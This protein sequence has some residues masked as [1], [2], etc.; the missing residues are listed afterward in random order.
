[1]KKNSQTTA[2]TYHS[3]VLDEFLSL[4]TPQEL[5]RTEKRM[6]MASKIADAM[7]QK[8]IANKQLAEKTGQ[9][10]SVITKWLSGGHNFTLDTL[11]DI[12]RALGVRLLNLEEKQAQQVEMKPIHLSREV[13]SDTPIGMPSGRS[14]SMSVSREGNT[15]TP[16][17]DFKRHLRVA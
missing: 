15:K 1:M 11:T 17:E 3:D 12:Q 14:F 16:L 13:S 2:Q 7:Q 10:P 6:L 8:K 9:S 5:E 4:G